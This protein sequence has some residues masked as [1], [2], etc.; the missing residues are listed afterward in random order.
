MTGLPSPP[1]RPTASATAATTTA[2][3]KLEL[4]GSFPLSGVVESMAV[5]RSRGGGSGG[6]GG[7]LGSSVSEVL[8]D[9]VLVTFRCDHLMN[10]DDLALCLEV[11]T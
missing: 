10:A 9:A 8:R 11:P 6:G 4:L 7:P 1:E 5:L 3:C 2:A